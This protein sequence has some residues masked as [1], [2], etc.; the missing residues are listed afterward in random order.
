MTLTDY[1][2]TLQLVTMCGLFV[3]ILFGGI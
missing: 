3:E 1:P 2:N